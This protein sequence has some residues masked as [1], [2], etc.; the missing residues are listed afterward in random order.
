MATVLDPTS[1]QVGGHIE[2][3]ESVLR[4]AIEVFEIAL[5]DCCDDAIRSQFPAVYD[6]HRRDY[7]RHHRAAGETDMPDVKIQTG[8]GEIPAYVARPAGAGPFPGVVV[9]HDIV[10]M[11]S[12]VK[13]HT[14]WFAGLGYLAVA[15]NL[16][17]WDGRLSCIR[18]IIRE[19]AARK[20]RSF[21]EIEATRAWLA[22]QPGCTGK[23]GVIGFCMGG[24][25]ALLLA[26]GRNGFAASAPCYGRVPDDVE[27]ILEGA[28]PVVAS[29]G[30][31]DRPLR[32]AA[33]KLERALTAQKIPHDVKE[34]P[35]ANHSFL[36]NHAASDVPAFF[37]V[38]MKVMG[39]GYHGPSADDAR[40]RISTFFDEHLK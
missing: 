20:G 23:I 31:K 40:R 15:P 25:F 26:P 39:V 34:Y 17:H 9:I 35:D 22:S 5:V 36:N 12:D 28:C 2:R 6:I 37:R 13:A 14:D 16:F 30:G 3:P 38:M 7:G 27:A 8:H 10:G 33:E 19:L 29:F 18:A 32:G 11:S 21:D 4:D 24:G 1:V